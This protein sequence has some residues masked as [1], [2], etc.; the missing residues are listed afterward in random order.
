[1]NA[2]ALQRVTPDR[3]FS[4]FDDYSEHNTFCKVYNDGSSYIAIPSGKFKGYRRERTF[5]PGVLD[6]LFDALYFKALK[7][8]VKRKEI[9]AYIKAGIL[10]RYPD[11][12]GVDDLIERNLIRVYR[13]LAAR[14][15]RFR[16][17]AYLNKWNYFV[18][19]TYS[20]EL[21]SSSFREV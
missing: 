3:T 5:I 10:E 18:T 20:D 13:N 8:N 1:M 4:W 21:Y 16:R 7:D 14:K 17:K 6:E 15:K 9:P 19:F 11:A 12:W 2:L